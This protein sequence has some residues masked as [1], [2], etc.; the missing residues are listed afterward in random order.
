LQ[1]TSGKIDTLIERS[2]GALM[3]RCYSDGGAEWRKKIQLWRE[4]FSHEATQSLP[5]TLKK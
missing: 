5:T 1:R 2:C 3:R 4:D